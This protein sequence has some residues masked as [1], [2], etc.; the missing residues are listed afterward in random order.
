MPKPK[1]K[2]YISR[3][4]LRTELS[5]AADCIIMANFGEARKIINQV[6]DRVE[7]YDLPGGKKEEG[8][9]AN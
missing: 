1:Q 6:L 2:H 5:V 3:A 9:I 4:V 8:A 7:E